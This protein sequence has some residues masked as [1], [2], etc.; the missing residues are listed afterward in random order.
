MNKCCH[1]CVYFPCT[2]NECDIKN[3]EGCK[4]CKTISQEVNIKM[5]NGQKGN[6]NV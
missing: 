6:K 5:T 3:V 2:K 1:N 4:L